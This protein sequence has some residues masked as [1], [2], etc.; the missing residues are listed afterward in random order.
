MSSLSKVNTGHTLQTQVGHEEMR[1]EHSIKITVVGAGQVG[2]AI[3]YA[4]IN[5]VRLEG[6]KRLKLIR[7]RKKIVGS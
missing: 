2:M 4:I 3:A 6:R 5:Q 1:H 7:N